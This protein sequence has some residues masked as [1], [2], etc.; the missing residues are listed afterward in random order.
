MF[1]VLAVYSYDNKLQTIVFLAT[2]EQRI[3]GEAETVLNPVFAKL[4]WLGCNSITNHIR[5]LV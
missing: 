1:V 3:F 4:L 2:S 5:C